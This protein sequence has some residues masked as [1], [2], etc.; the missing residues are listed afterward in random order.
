M[1][2]LISFKNN[3]QSI[4]EFFFSVLLGILRYPANIKFCAVKLISIF[5]TTYSCQSLYSTIKWKYRSNLTDDHLTELLGTAL[6]CQCNWILKSSREKKYHLNKFNSKFTY[7]IRYSY[8]FIYYIILF[9]YL[10][11]VK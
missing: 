3:C 8:L 5:G 10:F 11:Y 4:K 1:K 7:F 2:V 6:T 9:I